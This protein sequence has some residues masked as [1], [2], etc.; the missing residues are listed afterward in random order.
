MKPKYRSNLAPLF[1]LVGIL[2]ACSSEPS[3][4]FPDPRF[5]ITEGPVGTVPTTPTAPTPIA[6]APEAECTALV[7][8]VN[9][10]VGKVGLLSKAEGPVDQQLIA[11]SQSMDAASKRAQLLVISDPVLL[12]L[13][14]RYIDMANRS[15]KAAAALSIAA[16]TRDNVNGPRLQA[17]FEQALG[18]EDGIVDGIN[19]RC[20]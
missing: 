2:L 17:E 14:Q 15:A 5:P 12:G 18:E 8:E 1:P 11:V 6:K 20:Q 16:K 13:R 19:A 4:E 3:P 10:A 7:N 9:E